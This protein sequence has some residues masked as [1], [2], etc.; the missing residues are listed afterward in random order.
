[1]VQLISNEGKIVDVTDAAAMNSLFLKEALEP[2]QE[3]V[4][5]LL[6]KFD[7]KTLTKIKNFLN[8]LATPPP[9]P[10]IEKPFYDSDDFITS[11]ERWDQEFVNIPLNELLLLQKAVHFLQIKSLETL[12]CAKLAYMIMHNPPLLTKEKLGSE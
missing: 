9:M 8:R 2:K 1:M 10:E 3:D 4:K 11:V 6:D 12:I 5:I 7:F